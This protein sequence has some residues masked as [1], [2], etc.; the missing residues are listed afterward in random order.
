MVAAAI[1]GGAIIGGVASA[2]SS[3]Q[4][5][6][7]ADKVAA[8]SQSSNDASVNEARRQYDQTRADYQPFRDLGVGAT[9]RLNAA[10]NGDFSSFQASPSYDFTRQ[11]GQRDLGNS[12]AAKG[13]AASG[14][15]LRALSQYNQNLASGEYNNWFNQNLGLANIGASGTSGTAQAGANATNQI[16]G[17][18]TANV[19]ALSNSYFNGANAR[20]SGVTGAANSINSGI[21]N[22][23]Y[24]KNTFGKSANG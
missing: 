15:A 9:T 20:A 1:V 17:A 4:G 23:I 13:G 5:S 3:K 22:Y 19:N 21:G 24:Y 11:E 10:A 14:N 8:A 12:F 6:N 2:Y 16:V 18:N 7:A